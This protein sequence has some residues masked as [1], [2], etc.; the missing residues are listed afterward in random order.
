MSIFFPFFRPFAS[1]PVT[2]LSH[3][4]P[5]PCAKEISVRANPFLLLSAMLWAVPAQAQSDD[6]APDQ[7]W[8]VHGQATLVVQ[9]VGGF[10]SPY[11]GD[12][13]LMPN[14]T[15]ETADATLYLGVAPWKG[16]ELWVNPELDQ[17]FGLSDTLG[18]AGFPSAEAYKVGKSNPYFK[19]QRAFLR[20]TIALGGKA[21]TLDAAI[22]Q[23][24]LT[25]TQNR[26]VITAGKIGVGD[27]FDTNKYAHDPRGDFL[28][29]SLVDTGSFD[30]AANAWGYTYGAAAEW[31]QGDWTLRGGLFTLS[32]VPNGEALGTNLRQNQIVVEVEHR[33]TILGQQGAIR[34]TGFRNRGLFSRYDDA[35]ALARATGNLP[36]LSLTRRMQDRSGI[37]L[38]VE[39]D[40]TANLG[41]FLRAGA[42]D[43]AIEVYDFTDI[44]RTVALGA[45]LKGKGWGRAQDTLAIAAVRNGISQDFKTYLAAGGLGVLVGDGALTH[46]GD[47]QIFE[48]YYAFRPTG[49]ASMTL[50]YQHIANPGY[51]RDR[52]PANVLAMRLHAGF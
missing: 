18:V 19:L 52:G 49:W 16:A 28:N 5:R 42:A 12:N 41:A 44:D 46:P 45:A 24:R 35:M 30:Y 21:V 38:N 51:N 20:Q 43:G 48:A 13:S 29:W 6:P 17:G 37:S 32:Q 25:T 27:V 10:A 22:N 39:Q 9:G 14:Q 40:I 23:L 8:A 26:I 2:G 4:L 3:F 36:D 31:Y 33:H 15:K 47:E 34:V 7:R 1:I 11:T 50:D